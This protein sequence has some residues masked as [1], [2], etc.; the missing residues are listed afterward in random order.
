MITKNNYLSGGIMGLYK[1]PN[2][3]NWQMCFFVN[4]K[5]VRMSANTSNKK[6]AQ[7]IYDSLKGQVAEGKF[8]ITTSSD[9]PFSRL[10][11]EFIEKHSKVEKESYKTDILLGRQLKKYFGNRPIGKITALEI[12]EWRKWR[13][14]HIT[15]KGA[16]ITK[17]SLNRELCFLKTMFSHALEWEWLSE[18]PAS[19]IKFLKGEKSRM[20]F[21][22]NEEI[23]TLIDFADP[24][25]KPII[26][27]AIS[28]G[29]RLGEILNLKWQEVDFEHGFIRVVKSKNHES[30]DIPINGYLEETLKGLVESMKIGNYVFCNEIGDK[31]SRIDHFFAKARKLAGLED[32]RFHDLRHTAA[33]LYASRGCDIITLQNLLG[34]KKITMTQRYAHLIPESHEKTRRIMSDFWGTLGDTKNDTQAERPQEKSPEKLTSKSFS[35]SLLAD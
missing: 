17:A 16:R 28:T 25:L 4:G 34:H 27:T 20:R 15:R 7:R 30:R 22:C 33:S 8:K 29:K 11:D 9:M 31:I 6:V 12:K 3:S 5:K 10:V 14:E 1:R 13:S 32:F 24:F 26:I 35:A 18:N 19:K 23:C 21:L 2:S